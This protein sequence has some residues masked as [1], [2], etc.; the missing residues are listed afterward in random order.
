MAGRSVAEI[1]PKRFDELDRDSVD[2]ILRRVGAGGES[3]FFERKA[4]ARSDLLAKSCSA[5]ANTLGGLLVVGVPDDSDELVGITNKI[6]EP[7]LWVKDLLRGHVVPL[8]PFRAHRIELAN[9]RWLLLVLVEESSTTPHFTSKGAIYVRSGS[10]SEPVP[11]TEQR[12]L[13]ELIERGREASRRAYER[14]ITLLGVPPQPRGCRIVQ[15][16]ALVPS[17]RPR[18]ALR[19]LELHDPELE[20]PRALLQVPKSAPVRTRWQQFWLE[21][22]ARPGPR[23]LPTGAVL[24]GRVYAA[25]ILADG[26]IVVH[27]GV[28][29]DEWEPAPELD[30]MRQWLLGCLNRG[31]DLLLELGAHGDLRL[32]WR[33]KGGG[34]KT[35]MY[36]Q[37]QGERITGDIDMQTWVDLDTDEAADETMLEHLTADLLRALG[38]PPQR[39][40]SNG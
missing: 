24:P 32:A 37:Q 4:I 14:A 40:P 21:V 15:T 38:V 28:A 2:E 31:R 1:L 17:G 33:L 5:F 23:Y 35:L 22:E 16:V 9:G 12:T 13:F 6:S 36:A 27:D 20:R 30:Q 18:N 8:P 39:R 7:E 11:I 34:E 29:E 19:E 25:T 3:V 26:A 10:S